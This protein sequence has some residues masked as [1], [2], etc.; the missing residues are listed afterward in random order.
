MNKNKS[1]NNKC[2]FVAEETF[3]KSFNT[4]L[5][6]LLARLFIIDF[7]VERR[8][9]YVI[10]SQVKEQRFARHGLVAQRQ[11]DYIWIVGQQIVVLKINVQ[12]VV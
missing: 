4:L 6:S 3:E 12:S 10:Q 5:N 2:L 7:V 8:Q 1:V 11:F 9:L